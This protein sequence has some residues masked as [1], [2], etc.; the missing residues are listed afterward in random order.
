MTPAAADARHAAL[1]QA[2]SA[3]P[4]G[5]YCYTIVDVLPADGETPPRILT[6]TCPYWAQSSEHPEQSNGYCAHLKS[7]D[8]DSKGFSLLW[9]Q[10]KECGIHDDEDEPD[11]EEAPKA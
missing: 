6:R 1:N 4:K 5:M 8:W 3:I 11:H 9:D 2:E 7:G 10:V